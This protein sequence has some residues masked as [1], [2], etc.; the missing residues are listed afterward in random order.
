M[1]YMWETK[2]FIYIKQNEGKPNRYNWVKKGRGR[3]GIKNLPRDQK[4]TANCIQTLVRVPPFISA[5]YRS[6]G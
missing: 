1:Y 4:D 3:G 2:R 5:T 6:Q